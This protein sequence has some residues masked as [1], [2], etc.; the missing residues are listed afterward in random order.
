MDRVLVAGEQ[1][2]QFFQLGRLQ[3]AQFFHPGLPLL[4]RARIGMRGSGGG[5]GGENRAGI[6]GQPQ[7]DV[8]VFADCG[9]A[10]VDLHQRDFGRDAL[11]VA[12]AEIKRRADNQQHI[13]LAEGVAAG[14]VEMMRVVD[15]EHAA[16]R[17]V[18]VGG[19]VERAHQFNRG[20][21]PLRRPDL[22]AEQRRRALGL[23]EQLG[24]AFNI[25]RVADAA[26]RGT[27]MPRLRQHGLVNRDLA[28]Q[29]IARDF[30]IR[31]AVSAVK[32]FPRRHADHVRDPLGGIDPGGELGN[33]RQDVDMRQILQR[34]HLVLGQRALPADVQHRALRAKRGGDAGDRV[35][36]AGPGGGYHAAEF[37][38]LPG[39]AVGRMRGDLL[40]T[41]IHDAD[42]LVQTAVIDIDDMPAAERE[43][44]VHPLVFQRLGDQMA[45]GD[46]LAA[47]VLAD[48]SIGSGIK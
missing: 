25:R 17:P 9:I 38:G 21:V 26:R 43:Y 3:I 35:G 12:H 23:R 41:H 14:A 44:G 37:A 11:A 18:H 24:E 27:V 4:T 30:Q 28:V 20:L 2:H 6:A 15:G 33:R 8:A 40:M 39:I 19:D 46:D 7:V 22:L 16:A 47:L 1:G 48:Q 31:R 42:A 5:D 45:A 32:T 34:A 29:H 13:G 36:A 10:L